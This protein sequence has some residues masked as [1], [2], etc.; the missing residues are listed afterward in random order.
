MISRNFIKISVTVSSI[1][2]SWL[3]FAIMLPGAEPNSAEALAFW[4]KE[5]KPLLQQNCW[6]CHGAKERIKGDL[7]LTTRDGVLN[8]G[9]IGPSVNLEKPEASL[10]L[11]MISYKDEDHEMPPLGKLKEDEIKIFEKWIQLG[12][13]FDPKDEIHGKEDGHE[14]T[15][16]GG[17]TK[18]NERTM[19]HWSYLKPKR[20]ELPEVKD[21]SAKH[22]IDRFILSKLESAGLKPNPLA[23]KEALLR[24]AYYNLIGLA[25]GPDQVNEF[26]ADKSPDAY[27]KVI[28]ELLNS[29]QYGEKWG[30]HWLDLVRYA[31]TN[32]YERDS[33]KPNVWR[34]RDYV[35]RAFN[36]NKPYD[37]FVQEQ[38][39]GDELPDKDAD[40]ITATGFHRL[41]IWDDE[42]ADRKLARYDYLDDILRTTSDVFLGMSVGCARCHDHKIDP[43][44]TKDYY[45]LLSFFAN[46]S[47]HGKGGT[48]L[49]KVESFSGNGQFQGQY[50]QWKKR[51]D[52][53]RKQLEKIEK[54]FLDE[55]A[56]R[57]PEIK[58]SK[59][60][61]NTKVKQNVL[62]HDA[63][64]G[65]VNWNYTTK[66]PENHWFE[67]AYDD[68]KWET[69]KAGFGSKGTPGSVVRTEW[70]TPE[71]WLRTSFRLGSVPNNL[72]LNVHHDEDVSI[73]LNGKLIKKLSG[74]V[75]KYETHDVSKE[76]ADVLQ[77]GKNV[78]A[79]HCRQTSG[80]QYV[81]VGVATS[82]NYAD[83]ASL[84][85]KFGKD[86]VGD[87]AVKSYRRIEKDLT[88]HSAKKPSASKYDVMAV[89]ESGNNVIK[90]LRRGNPVLEGDVVQPAFPSVLRP[91]EAIIP[92]D[93]K[94][95]RTSGRRRV[96]AEWITSK[97]N[98]VS[99]RVMMNRVWQH[100]FGRGI[101]RSTSDFGFQGIEPTHPELLDWL[102]TE[103]MAKDW[104][105]KAMHKLL[106]TSQAYQRSSAPSKV[107][108]EKDPINDLF[109]R[110]DMRRLTAEEVRDS[111]LGA[112]GTLNLK[113]GGPSITPPL[114][115]IVLATASRIGAGWGKSSPDESNRRSVYVKVKRSMQMPILIN[116]DMADMDTSCPVRFTTTVPTQS[117]NMLNGKFMNDSAKL[118]AKRL[119]DE[120]G[121]DPAAQ[122]AHALQITFSR[123]PADK[124]IAA[125]LAMIKDIQQKADL[126][127]EVALER[128]AL[129]ALNLNEFIYLD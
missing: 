24:R 16:E 96:L 59:P 82:D 100:H 114:P 107:N 105:I 3:S 7:R 75:S 91:P 56:K 34:Y 97:E 67:I 30:R 50:D 15:T 8:G 128:F 53:L 108:F 13:P 20:T 17:N 113:P 111:V 35:I 43:I 109:W 116:H 55:L 11:E 98:P 69:G 25:P 112:C 117:L 22:P 87:A 12:L 72:S 63:R 33:E 26:L 85:R 129:L 123:K 14:E 76:A 21:K 2:L 64:T 115:R 36:Q 86:Y 120:A 121:D 65:Q 80:G 73:Y 78:I 51:E 1:G 27:E 23:A 38:L 92:D 106:M 10:L 95:P 5:A 40:S 66:K 99:A 48:N 79:V 119:R 103:F 88:N 42:P 41:G 81:D 4:Q 57:Q 83:L 29:P 58:V 94:T 71:I 32:G 93:Y 44:P 19:A 54:K 18:V 70:R 77:T 37:R 62:L 49:V 6:K 74:H 47:N 101:V 68:A 110:F 39:A 122:V 124:E 52:D 60:G 125:G 9:E 89:A 45:S 84:M 31:E 127:K 126:S 61:K 118:F 104:D 90:V 46:V 102:A 28:D